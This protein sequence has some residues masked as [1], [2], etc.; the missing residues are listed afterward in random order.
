[1]RENQHLSLM[2]LQ[3]M[4]LWSQ[5]TSARKG[6][7][8]F[9]RS[10]NSCF[11]DS[12]FLFDRPV[13]QELLED[14]AEG[15]EDDGEVQEPDAKKADIGGMGWQVWEVS[16]LL[17][18]SVEVRIGAPQATKKISWRCGLS[19]VCRNTDDEQMAGRFERLCCI[20]GPLNSRLTPLWAR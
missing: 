3:W 6:R 2:G 14:E 5:D 4:G 15:A 11:L 19:V 20:D 12:F 16:G 8:K 17:W 1:M 7:S 18:R 13:A 9:V 10:S